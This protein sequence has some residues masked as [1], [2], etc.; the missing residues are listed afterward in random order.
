MQLQPLVDALREVVL[1]Q[2]VVHADERGM[3]ALTA[4]NFEQGFVTASAL[5]A[6][7]GYPNLAAKML[8]S[9]G[10]QA[11]NCTA[12]PLDELLKMIVAELRPFLAD[13]PADHYGVHVENDIDARRLLYLVEKIG[14]E[15]VTRSASKYSEKYPGSRVFVSDLLKRYGVKVTPRVYTPVNVPL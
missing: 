4:F 15:K 3:K 13:L 9:A 6:R 11:L 7:L 1:A 5:T 14:R 2:R 8:V 10:S 12:K